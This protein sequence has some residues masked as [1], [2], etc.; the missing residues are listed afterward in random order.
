[1]TRIDTDETWERQPDGTTR[2]VSQSQRLA[3]DEDIENE[4]AMKN[5]QAA[6]SAMDALLNK[7][8]LKWTSTDTRDGAFLA[9]MA[10][11]R[12]MRRWMWK[13]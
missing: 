3:S 9:L 10:V 2:L 4:Q 8:R 6:V 11:R 13:P 12:I 1:M 5:L 7:G